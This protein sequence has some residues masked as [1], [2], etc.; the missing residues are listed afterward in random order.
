MSLILVPPVSAEIR[1]LPSDKLTGPIP[2][3]LLCQECLH[4]YVTRTYLMT[5][6]KNQPRQGKKHS[7]RIGLRIKVGGG[8]GCQWEDLGRDEVIN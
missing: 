4:M 2:S 8:G 7:Q 3:Q 5:R 6:H 1:H